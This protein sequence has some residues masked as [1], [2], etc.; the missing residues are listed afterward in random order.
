MQMLM[1]SSTPDPQQLCASVLQAVRLFLENGSRRRLLGNNHNISESGP[2]GD[3][4]VTALALAR[5]AVGAA[6]GSR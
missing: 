5:A 4:D 1:E 6:A 2:L 3:N